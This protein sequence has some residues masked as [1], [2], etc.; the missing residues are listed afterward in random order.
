MFCNLSSVAAEQNNLF[1][2]T[3]E[4]V[5]L[6]EYLEQVNFVNGFIIVLCYPILRS[7]MFVNF[8]VEL[9]LFLC[10]SIQRC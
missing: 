8:I 4:T 10:Q 2:N 1:L 5:T 7:W 3:L 6:Y 9:I